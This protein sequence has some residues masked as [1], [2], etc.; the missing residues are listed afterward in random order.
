[1]RR[2]PCADL[3]VKDDGD[4]RSR[5]EVADRE[6]VVVTEPGPAMDH[7]ERAVG[8]FREVTEKAV[9]CLMGLAVDREGDGPFRGEAA[10]H[11]VRKEG[12]HLRVVTAR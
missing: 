8:A 10:R 12:I 6:E 11:T 5:C 9:P 3:V 1:M 4:G 7:D 2:A